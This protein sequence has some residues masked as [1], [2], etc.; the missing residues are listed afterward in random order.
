MN[1]SAANLLN[2]FLDNVGGS[3]QNEYSNGSVALIRLFDEALTGNQVGELPQ[4]P[5]AVP[6]PATLALLVPGLLAGI[7]ARRRRP[8]QA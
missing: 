7:A 2:F 1:I 6:E 8:A 4:S 3:G 5:T